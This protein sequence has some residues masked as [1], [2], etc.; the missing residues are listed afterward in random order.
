MRTSTNKELR[1]EFKKELK[2]K[3][4]KCRKPAVSII[5]K[6]FVCKECFNSIKKENIDKYWGKGINIP[7]N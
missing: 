4:C 7:N 2:G 6:Q 5:R 3:K 1:I